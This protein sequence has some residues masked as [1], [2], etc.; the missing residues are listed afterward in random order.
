MVGL[1]ADLPALLSTRF[2]TQVFLEKALYHCLL[3]FD[4]PH[5]LEFS[6]TELNPYFG[7]FVPYFERP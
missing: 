4:S 2:F 6:I 7:L 3:T 1:G 5:F